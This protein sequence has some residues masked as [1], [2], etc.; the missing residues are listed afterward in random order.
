MRSPEKVTQVQRVPINVGS[1]REG[2]GKETRC[3]RKGGC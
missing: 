3:E 1:V 2:D